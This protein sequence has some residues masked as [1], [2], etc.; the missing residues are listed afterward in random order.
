MDASRYSILKCT[1]LLDY[2]HL[3]LALE[4]TEQESSL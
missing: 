4:G 2:R 3:C 1:H